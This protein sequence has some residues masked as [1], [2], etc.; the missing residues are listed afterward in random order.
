MADLQFL[1]PAPTMSK[2]VLVIAILCCGVAYLSSLRQA[3]SLILK[4]ILL[5]VFP[6]YDSAVYSNCSSKIC[7]LL[8]LV[9]AKST[10]CCRISEISFEK[11]TALNELSTTIT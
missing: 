11:W 1:C 10:N 9:Q 5:Y 7:Y 4:N 6:R 8:L 2:T 3:T